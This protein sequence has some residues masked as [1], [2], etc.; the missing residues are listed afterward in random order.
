MQ[1]CTAA[2]E[3]DQVM[4]VV[5]RDWTVRPANVSKQHYIARPSHTQ[6]SHTGDDDW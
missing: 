3:L 4:E 2:G 5:V 6:E 1:L